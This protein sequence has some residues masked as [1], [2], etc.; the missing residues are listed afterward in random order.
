MNDASSRD[1][2][3]LFEERL[4]RIPVPPRPVLQRRS[5]RRR[6]AG[7]IAAAALVAATM[8]TVLAANASAESQ[9]ATCADLVTRFQLLTGAV[10]VVHEGSDATHQGRSHDAVDHCETHGSTLIVSHR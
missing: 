10:H 1:L 4:S 9:G 8:G 3:L 7:T 5:A 2:D 6:I